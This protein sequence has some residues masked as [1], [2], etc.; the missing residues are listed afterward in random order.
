[1]GFASLSPSTGNSPAVAI[2][3]LLPSSVSVNISM[4]LEHGIDHSRPLGRLETQFKWWIEEELLFG[5]CRLCFCC[6]NAVTKR[7][8]RKTGTVPRDRH[9]CGRAMST[10]DPPAF[11]SSGLRYGELLTPTLCALRHV[12]GRRVAHG[13]MGH[14]HLEGQAVCRPARHPTPRS[15]ISPVCRIATTRNTLV[16]TWCQNTLTHHEP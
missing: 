11:R 6:R 16:P 3:G 1:M 10:A 7:S 9:N 15:P 4:R 12:C 5:R 8:R 13:T 14:D 2:I